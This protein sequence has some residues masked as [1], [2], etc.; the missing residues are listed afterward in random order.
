V[1]AD[2]E[3]RDGARTRTIL[4]LALP[5]AG[6]AA[7][8]LAH[9]WVDMAWVKGL[10]EAATGAMGVGT[11]S[12]W[13]FSALGAL[14]GT[15]LTALVARYSGA[16]REDA[17]GYVASQGLRWALVIGAVGAVLGWFLA[18]VLFLLSHSTESETAHGIPYTRIYWGGGA[19]I[20]LQLACDAVFRAH[21]NTRTPFL[22]GLFSLA[23]NVVLDPLLIFGWGPVP[24]LGMAGAGLAHVSSFVVGVLL[25]VRALRRAGHLHAER[26]SDAALRLVETTRLGRPNRWG[27]DRAVFGRM[28]RVGVPLGIT[29]LLF[30]AIY[31]A[32]YALASEAGGQAAHAGLVV[33]HN[34]EGVAF[35][36][37]MGWGG[38][39][40]ALVGRSLGAGRPEEAERYA[41]TAA[42]Q[43]AGLSGLWG[44]ALFLFDDEVA[45]L[46][47]DSP[48]GLRYAS[49]YLRIVAPCLL[50]QAFELVLDGAFG[51]AGL[52]LPPLVIGG[53]FTLLR[54]PAAA[55][56]VLTFGHGPEAI[57]VVISV[58]AALRGI[59]CAWW[60]SRGT[61]KARTV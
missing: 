38:A 2:P 59:G 5:A 12:V 18:P 31:I 40:A 45:G 20:L 57:W 30:N 8:V 44:L 34:G 49:A 54:I 53:S 6:S 21:G 47:V 60:F 29:S 50:F 43:C 41:W 35:V 10:G 33:G 9:R 17:G 46:L 32:L 51:G 61:W 26:P 55:L 23:L 39:A 19:A 14:I 7:L 25:S 48:D 36:L 16:G 3:P 15:G 28:A 56:A 4:S 22:I 42:L 52:T 24:A 37:G 1:S 58:T 27:L 11:I 13:M